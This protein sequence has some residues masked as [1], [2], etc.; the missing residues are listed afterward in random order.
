MEQTMLAADERRALRLWCRQALAQLEQEELKD[1]LLKM[2]KQEE[3]H[4]HRTSS[5]RQRPTRHA[6]AAHNKELAY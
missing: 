5:T 4:M 6:S 1:R 3:N 2:D